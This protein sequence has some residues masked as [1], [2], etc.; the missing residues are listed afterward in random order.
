M[1]DSIKGFTFVS[2]YVFYTMGVRRMDDDRSKKERY[3]EA[4]V[5]HK[6]MDDKLQL[7]VAEPFLTAEEE[8]EVRFLKKEKLRYK[9]TMERLKEEMESGV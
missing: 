7:L 4:K 8:V 6:T 3:D 9:D 1:D 2:P 5:L